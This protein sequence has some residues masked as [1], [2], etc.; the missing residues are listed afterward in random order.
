MPATAPITRTVGDVLDR[1]RAA[2][3]DQIATI[4]ARRNPGVVTWGVKFGD[5][6]KLAKQIKRDSDLARD[7]WATGILEARLLACKIVEPTD[8]SEAEIDRWVQDL[9]FPTLAD[10]FAGVVYRT[11]FARDKMVAWTGS[12]AEFVRRAGFVLVADFAA[13]PSSDASDAELRAYLDQIRTEIHGSP[14]WARET[15]NL[16]PIA[17]GKRNEALFPLAIETAR[18]YGKVAVF[19]GDKTNCKVWDAVAALHDPKVVFKAP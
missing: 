3:S 12:G 7:L 1:F 10:F 2:K 15:M 18:V 17:I 14:N 13:D 9:D 11:P 5:M 19:H 8:L 4:Y 6:D 16:V